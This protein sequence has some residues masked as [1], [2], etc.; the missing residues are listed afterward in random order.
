MT[1]TDWIKLVLAIWIVISVC[2]FCYWVIRSK[3]KAIDKKKGNLGLM[4]LYRGLGVLHSLFLE[5]IDLSILN[6]LRK[7]MNI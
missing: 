3:I 1:A 6:D 5:R 2:V 4:I 7:I